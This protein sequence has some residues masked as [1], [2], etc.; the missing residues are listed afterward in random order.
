MCLM[1]AFL[2]LQMMG[3]WEG[4]LGAFDSTTADSNTPQLWEQN[5]GIHEYA[6]HNAA[7]IAVAA[8]KLRPEQP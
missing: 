4:G 5:E 8:S 3:Q 7:I 6:E 1:S 2:M